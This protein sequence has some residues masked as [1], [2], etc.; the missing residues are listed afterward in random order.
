MEVSGG[1]LNPAAVG[2]GRKIITGVLLGVTM[3]L[4][5][6][7]HADAEDGNGNDFSRALTER[8]RKQAE[9]M[10]DW[11]RELKAAPLLIVSSPYPRAH[12]TANLL[13][14]SLGKDTTAR[15][16]ERL[17]PGM[18]PDA[19]S[20]VIHEFGGRTERLMLVGHSPDLDRLAAYLVGAKEGGVEMRKGAIACLTAARAGFG[21][22]T[23]RWLIDPKL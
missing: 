9:K 12:E 17:A 21:G 4:Y 6:M 22:S 23:L 7:R 11:L 10:G 1:G 2:C 5:L 18:T 20:A 14:G 16:D 3:E 15:P 19:A 8:G 13:A